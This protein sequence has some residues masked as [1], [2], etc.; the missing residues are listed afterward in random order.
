MS[1]RRLNHRHRLHHGNDHA[2]SRPRR[3]R[4]TSPTA[5]S[6][7][8]L[9]DQSPA[10]GSVSYR[11]S[12]NQNLHKPDFKMCGD[13]RPEIQEN[14][15]IDTVVMTVEASDDDPKESGGTVM[16]SMVSS[17]SEHTGDAFVVDQDTGV[18]RTRKIFDR[19]EPA[20]EKEIYVTVRATDNGHP[21]LDAVCT[22]KVKIIDVNDNKPMFDKYDYKESIPQDHSIGDVVM[23]ISATDIDDGNNGTIRYSLKADPQH[24]DDLHYFEIVPENGEVKLKKALGLDKR[25]SLQAVAKDMGEPPQENSISLTIEVVEPHKKPPV[26]IPNPNFRTHV[27]LNET[28]N[29][30]S[31][32]IVRI[33]ARSENDDD[34]YFELLTGQTEPTNKDKV[35][36]IDQVKNVAS[37]KLDKALDYE[38]VSNYALTIRAVNK[39]NLA[40]ETVITVEIEDENDEKPNFLT[41][42]SFREGSVLEDEPIGTSVIRVRAHDNDGTAPNNEVSLYLEPEDEEYFSIEPKSGILKTRKKFDREEKD[43]YSVKVIARDGAP[44]AITK[45]GHPNERSQ[46]FR[47][48]IADKNDNIPSFSKTVYEAEINEDA[49]LNAK[50]IEVKAIDKDTASI[51]TYSITQGN[52]GDA[53]KIEH[54]KTGKI[55]I[56]NSLDYETHRWYNLTIRA[57][58]SQF[59][60]FTQVIINVMNINDNPPVFEPTKTNATFAEGSPI[61]TYCIF[62]VKA[63]DPDIGD[64]NQP[65][66]IT[67]FIESGVNKFSVDDDGCVK[68]TQPLDADPP[69][70]HNTHYLRVGAKDEWG[71]GATSLTGYQELAVHLTDINDNKPELN[72]T[73]PVVWEENRPAGRIILLT[74]H[75]KDTEQN[76]PPFSFSI[77]DTKNTDPEI[78]TLFSIRDK[79]LYASKDNFDREYRKSYLIPIAITDSGHPQQTGTSTLTVIIG[80]EN[81]NNMEPGESKI[82]VYKYKQN[83]TFSIGRVYVKDPDDWD[84]PYKTFSWE[85]DIAAAHFNLDPGT[86][87]IYMK[88]EISTGTYTLR[89]KVYDKKWE[90]TVTAV[91][92]VTVKEIPEEAVIQ[93]GSIRFMTTQ[94][95]FIKPDSE[96]KSK[97]D[98]LQTEIAKTFNIPEENVDVFTVINSPRSTDST[99]DVRYSAH[100]SPYYKAEK[101]DGI[102]GQRKDELEKALELNILMIRVDECLS[103]TQPKQPGYCEL[104]CTNVLK[105]LESP[106]IIYTNESTFVGVNAFVEPKCECAAVETL[107]TCLPNPC[108]NNGICRSVGGKP[109]F[110]CECDEDIG[111]TG[112]RC[113]IASVSLEGNGYAWYPPL[114]VCDESSLDI[115]ISTYDSSGLILYNGPVYTAPSPYN[116]SDFISIELRNG[117]PILNLDYGSGITRIELLNSPELSDGKNHKI[118][119]RWSPNKIEMKVDECARKEPGCYNSTS[120]RGSNSV[121]NVNGPLQLGGLSFNPSKLRSALGWSFVPTTKRFTGCVTNLTFNGIYYNLG[122]P[123]YIVGNVS[124][125]A[126]PRVLHHA[127]LGVGIHFIIILIV[128]ILILL[129]LIIAI[130]FY[131]RRR[132]YEE[133]KGDP[134]DD[135]R[136]NIINYSDEGGGEGDQTGYDLSVLMK[137]TNGPFI[138]PTDKIPLD[139][140]RPIGRMPEPGDGPDIQ[141]F[142]QGNKNKV[143]NDPDGLPYDDVRNYAYE[144]DGNSMGSLSS[145]ASGTDDGDLNFDYLP[146]FGPRFKKLADMYGGQSSDDESYAGAPPE[147]WC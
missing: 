75:D 103:E 9:K 60:A 114:T 127:S 100:G 122:E 40:A 81:D 87:D 48:E 53:F 10:P 50:V 131:R 70:G 133:V 66:N 28:Y 23:R 104:S 146:T 115:H 6:I 55:V 36:Y 37:L 128:S 124:S 96:G 132:S 95:Q 72:C 46:V 129:L 141:S 57:S 117:H 80:D 136:E 58:D 105:T 14:Q 107:D 93:S 137:P 32:A 44:S 76:G 94:E 112:P 120:P 71:K 34:I 130:V 83:S 3:G 68:V 69:D 38:K 20:R 67:Y 134:H 147:A 8:M 33:E 43:F 144:G 52:V 7:V 113:E 4:E 2:R 63:Y 22:I 45:D 17:S 74:A 106:Y 35:F 30:K 27:K 64:R 41:L 125:C 101:L 82:F 139:D 110:S 84:L 85:N 102:T 88:P 54:D 140:L 90:S 121:L 61:P 51:I 89:F 123:S 92:N 135:V 42:E 116:N 49:N 138:S 25:F 13:Y 79:S 56:K 145:L 142:L 5:P 31:A 99:I 77:V 1:L 24:P 11:V 86:G 97:R 19:D 109:G 98:R 39:H 119:L 59:D 143:D 65:Q 26:F 62:E 12:N 21:Q 108:L 15:P 73:N 91:V 78:R 118:S 126:S 29:D 111:P 18:L 16:Y 47:I